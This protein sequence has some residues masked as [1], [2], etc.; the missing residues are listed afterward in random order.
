MPKAGYP[1]VLRVPGQNLKIHALYESTYLLI[2]DNT[3]YTQR[4]RRR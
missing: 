4:R 2:A 3:D 1:S